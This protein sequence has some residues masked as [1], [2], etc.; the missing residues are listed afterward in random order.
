MRSQCVVPGRPNGKMHVTVQRCS[1]HGRCWSEPVSP[2]HY[3]S[4]LPA[5][6]RVFAVVVVL[7]ADPV[8]PD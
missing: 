5:H 7:D 6:L 3:Y 2:L 1:A 4:A 8:L